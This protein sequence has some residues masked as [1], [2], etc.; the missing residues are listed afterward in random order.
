MDVMW[1]A[2]L[3]CASGGVRHG[4]AEGPMAYIADFLSIKISENDG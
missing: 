3:G 4:K 2:L 1:L